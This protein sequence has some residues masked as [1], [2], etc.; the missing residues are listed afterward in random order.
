[1]TA[2]APAP[3]DLA[4]TLRLD[5]RPADTGDTEAAFGARLTSVVG[6]AQGRPDVTPDQQ[7]AHARALLIGAQ[8]RELLRQV[9]VFRREGKITIEQGISARVA[10]LR[11]DERVA[12]AAAGLSPVESG[13]VAR[14]RS[15]V[16]RP[17]LDG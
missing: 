6:R 12:L 15:V 3:T 9:E 2:P 14:P 8:I 10:Q 4:E 17:E 13:L 5:F 11:L 16:Y 7:E 1:M